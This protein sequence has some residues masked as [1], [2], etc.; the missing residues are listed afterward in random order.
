[1]AEVEQLVGVDG[2]VNEFVGAAADHHHRRDRALGKIFADGL[3]MPARAA[4]VGR[5][6]ASVDGGSERL[7]ITARKVDEGR[8]EIDE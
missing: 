5:E 6:R 4:E 7:R 2:G 8:H 3:V 1:M